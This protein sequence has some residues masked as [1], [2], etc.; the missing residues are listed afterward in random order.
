M[1]IYIHTCIQCIAAEGM[2]VKK[3]EVD[4]IVNGIIPILFSDYDGL[5]F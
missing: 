5:N 2:K 1:K 4:L 3:K